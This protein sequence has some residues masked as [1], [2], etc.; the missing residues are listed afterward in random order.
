MQRPLTILCCLVGLTTYSTTAAA[1]PLAQQL[2][3]EAQRAL[4]QGQIPRSITLYRGLWELTHSFGSLQQMARVQAMAGRFDQ[5]ITTN[6]RVLKLNPPP[7][8]AANARAEIKRLKNTPAPFSDELAKG[9][10]ATVFAK[11]AFKQGLRLARRKKLAPA[12]RF[13]RAALVLDPVLPGTYRVLGGIHGKL[14]DPKKERA[15]LQDYLRIRPDGTI[16]DKVRSRLKAANVLGKLDL[17]ASFA[18]DVW[19]NGRPM[20]LTT[21][22]KDLLL[23]EGSYTVSFANADLHIVRNKRVKIKPNK[24]ARVSFAF[25]VLS[26]KLK[27]WARARASGKALGLWDETGLPVGTYRLSLV[28]HDMSRKKTIEL[29]MRAGKKVTISKW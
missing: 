22:H 19:I 15:F 14:K 28:A 21:P 25:G 4:V 16:A 11:L 9:Y 2:E 29:T 7:V 10:R 17:R 24:T 18:C 1:A 23:P 5:A 6:E 12:I 27:P 13:L 20:G 3:T 8:V 26:L